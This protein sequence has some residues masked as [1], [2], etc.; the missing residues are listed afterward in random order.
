MQEPS[1][2]VLQTGN[3]PFQHSALAA[4]GELSAAICEIEQ[5]GPTARNLLQALSA[6]KPD[7]SLSDI[8]ALIVDHLFQPQVR[9]KEGIFSI[10][11]ALNAS[12]AFSVT[13]FL[14]MSTRK[15]TV[16]FSSMT[17]NSQ[18]L[19]YCFLLIYPVQALP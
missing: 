19:Q 14:P 2:Q 11:G 16:Q 3:I 18:S 1:V 12:I 15:P 6:C 9:F 13:A 4:T 17:I 7:S 10:I 8:K 5:I